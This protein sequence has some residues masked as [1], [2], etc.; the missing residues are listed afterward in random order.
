MESSYSAFALGLL[1]HDA[2]TQ[3]GFK[4]FEMLKTLQDIVKIGGG[5]SRYEITKIFLDFTSHE[6]H[7]FIFT[8]FRNTEA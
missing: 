3:K 2:E 5:G 7:N 4:L 8:N 1:Q 6:K